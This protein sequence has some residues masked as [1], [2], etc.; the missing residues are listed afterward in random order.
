MNNAAQQSDECCDKQCLKNEVIGWGVVIM[1]IGL[2]LLAI[3]LPLSFNYV[4]YDQFGFTRNK[5]GAVDYSTV[6]TQGRLFLPLSYG[7]VLFPTTFQ[8]VAYLNSA[9]TSLSIFTNEGLTFYIDL[10][11]YYRLKKTSLA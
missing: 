8:R 10:S 11:F 7:V 4:N 2:V 9:G 1:I 5:F 6:I 3:M